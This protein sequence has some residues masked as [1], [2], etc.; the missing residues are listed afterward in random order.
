MTTILFIR[1]GESET[2]KFIHQ[3]PN[4]PYLSDKINAVGDPHLTDNGNMQ[5]KQVGDYLISYL[6]DK[7][8]RVLTSLFT[9]TIETSQPFCDEYALNIYTN[10]S[11][12][13]LSEY[14]K[15]QKKLTEKHLKKGLRNHTNWDDFTK[16][17]EECV[18]ILE[19]MAQCNNQP[20]IV[21][22]H[23]LYISVLTSYLGSS[24]TFMP[25]KNQLTFRFPNCSITSYEYSQGT[26]RIFNVAS[27]AHLTQNVI[28]G[29]ECPFG[30]VPKNDE[31]VVY[32]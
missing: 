17:I 21:F 1:H 32:I 29:T 30:N 11:L 14:T 7:K 28:T 4:D 13:I 19:D 23:S 8:V 18:D 9:R 6:K 26:W 27:I 2:N 16:T 3:D 12:E 15:P 24:K 10:E 31:D 20:I 22:G 5:S 25:E